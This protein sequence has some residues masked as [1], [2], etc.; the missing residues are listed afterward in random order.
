MP[1]QSE[2]GALLP[3]AAR[4]AL[5]AQPSPELAVERPQD[6]PLRYAAY[7]SRAAQLSGRVASVR[8]LAYASDV[9]EA[10]RPTVPRWVVNASYGVAGA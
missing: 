1:S 6:G 4:A 9:G 7:A 10:F 2:P 5:P 8:H 3:P